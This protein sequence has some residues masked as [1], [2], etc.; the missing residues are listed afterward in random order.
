MSRPKVLLADDDEALL[1]VHV[2]ELE[3]AGLTCILAGSGAETLEK[4]EECQPDVVVLDV[5]LPDMNR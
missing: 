5:R 3:K 2:P 1:N 4:A